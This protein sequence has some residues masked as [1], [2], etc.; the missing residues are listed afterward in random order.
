MIDAHIGRPQIIEIFKF[1]SFLDGE[2]NQNAPPFPVG[3]ISPRVS[4]SI[5]HFGH[6]LWRSRGPSERQG[7]GGSPI[8]NPEY[9]PQSARN[10]EAKPPQTSQQI[11]IFKSYIRDLI[12]RN[13]GC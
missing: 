8:K 6:F 7:D 3:K 1:K 10:S 11:A 5:S 13:N 4:A 2:A 9:Q 12:S